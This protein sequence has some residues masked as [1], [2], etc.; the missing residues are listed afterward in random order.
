MKVELEKL[1]D[2]YAQLVAD[3]GAE[4]ASSLASRLFRSRNTALALAILLRE[5]KVT[6]V[7]LQDIG[8]PSPSSYRCIANLRRM[9]I[10]FPSDSFQ[11]SRG[12][13]PHTKVWRLRRSQ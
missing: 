2:A 1:I 13:G 3:V 8:I 10:I 11:A 5:G 4:R 6:A 7:D 12:G 9:E